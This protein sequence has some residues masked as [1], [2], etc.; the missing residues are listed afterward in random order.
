[1]TTPRPDLTP[2]ESRVRNALHMA[3]VDRD[4][5]TMHV[6]AL[7]QPPEDVRAWLLQVASLLGTAD[8]TLWE[9]LQTGPIPITVENTSHDAINDWRSRAVDYLWRRAN[10][11]MG[12]VIVDRYLNGL[13]LSEH[14]QK[15]M[16]RVFHE[17]GPLPGI[18]A[19]Q[20]SD[21]GWP[22]HDPLPVDVQPTRLPDGIP[23]NRYRCPWCDC[24]TH[25]GPDGHCAICGR[26]QDGTKWDTHVAAELPVDGPAPADP[27]M[28]AKLPEGGFI[29]A[30]C[31]TCSVLGGHDPGC[32]DDDGHVDDRGEAGAD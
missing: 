13:A 19:R 22:T 31:P 12:Y 30:M 11:V 16:T 1:M 25:D 20:A 18:T 29:A 27:S 3:D 17:V 32:P 21:Q 7:M 28:V 4:R 10:V 5:T 24:T 15:I 23:G 8:V 26:R 14:D 6:L 9:L 2:S